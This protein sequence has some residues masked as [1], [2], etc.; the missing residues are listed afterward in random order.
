MLFNRVKSKLQ[1]MKA[2]IYDFMLTPRDAFTRVNKCLEKIIIKY[3]ING[4]GKLTYDEFKDFAVA[5]SQMARE[6]HHSFSIMKDL[7]DFIDCK[8]DGVIDLNEWLQTFNSL[9]VFLDFCFYSLGTSDLKVLC[10][11]QFHE[12]VC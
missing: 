3:N 7:F 6:E 5:L 4:S 2:N 8:K 11:K 1:T 10:R 12:F 9:P